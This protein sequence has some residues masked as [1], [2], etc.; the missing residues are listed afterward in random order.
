MYLVMDSELEQLARG[1]IRVEDLTIPENQAL[2]TWSGD[3]IKMLLEKNN[4]KFDLQEAVEIV[5]NALENCDC[6]M[7]VSCAFDCVKDKVKEE[8]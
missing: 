6:A 5:S 8:M 4:L 2:I 1:E 7:C 3:D